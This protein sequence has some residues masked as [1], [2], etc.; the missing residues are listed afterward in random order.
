MA[1]YVTPRGRLVHN[2]NWPQ[3]YREENMTEVECDVYVPVNVKV[4][5]DDFIIS[6]LMPGVKA[7]DLS[8]QILNETVTIQGELKDQ[9]KEGE[10]YLVRECPAGRFYRVIRLPEQLDSNKASADLSDGL[11]TLRVPKVEEA[12]PKTIQVKRIK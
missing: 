8:I 10:T 12:R 11:L 7:E 4:E 9:S 2:R 5:D 6:A 3:S 1:F